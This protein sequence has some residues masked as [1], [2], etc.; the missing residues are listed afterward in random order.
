MNYQDEKINERESPNQNHKEIPG[1][2]STATSS[3]LKLNDRSNGKELKVL[4]EDDWK[5]WIEN[6]YV[7]IKNAVPKEQA[8]NTAEFL[9][10]FE[11]KSDSE[12]ERFEVQVNFLGLYGTSSPL[13]VFYTEDLIDEASD[14]ESVAREF[15]ERQFPQFLPTESPSER[16]NIHVGAT[17]EVWS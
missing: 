12:D 15:I 17:S 8:T 14:D 3:E 5:F 13:P 11:E 9:W 7:I 4:S 16:K 2:P 6:G 1:N 10:E